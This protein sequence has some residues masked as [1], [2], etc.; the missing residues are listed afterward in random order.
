MIFVLF[1]FGNGYQ[2]V[3]TTFMMEP[4]QISTFKTVDELLDSKY[5]VIVGKPFKFLMQNNLKFKKALSE[6]RIF[7]REESGKEIGPDFSSAIFGCRQ[8]EIYYRY[9]K[10]PK[11]HFYILPEHVSAL[12]NYVQLDVGFMNPF[13]TRIQY[14]MDLSFEAGLPKAWKI[15]HNDF[16]NH[17]VSSVR[18]YSLNRHEE[19]RDILDLAQILPICI[20]LLI[21]HSL[22]FLTLLCEIFYHDFVNPFYVLRKTN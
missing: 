13:L 16:M 3:V 20:I 9:E 14:L 8:A 18:G 11:V 12:S 21:G 10:F 6:N 4:M 7:V 15:F 5:E 19:T 17:Y 22:A 1:I 2:S